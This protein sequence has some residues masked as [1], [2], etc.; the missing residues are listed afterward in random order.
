M[1]VTAPP[2]T[3]LPFTTSPLDLVDQDHTGT[4]TLPTP[5]PTRRDQEPARRVHH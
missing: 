2:R 5:I 1:T 4:L 3:A